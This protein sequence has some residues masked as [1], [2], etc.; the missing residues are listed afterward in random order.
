MLP[1]NIITLSH[2][3]ALGWLSPS[4]P[5]LRSDESHLVTGPVSSDE[6]SWIGSSLCIGGFIGTI[7]FG[8]I[9][10]M[11][12][13]KKAL[14]LLVFPHLCFWLLVL[15]ST[16]IYHLYIARVCAGLT[17]GGTLRTVSL[18]ITEISENK[19][20]GRLGSYLI[21]FLCTGTLL[22]FIAG[23]Y[24]SFFTVPYVMLMFPVTF[25]V[26]VLFLP[27]TPQ[28]LMS[29]NKADEAWD[30]LMFYRTCGA[31][32]VATESV[33]EEFQVLKQTLEHQNSEKL[34]LKDFRKF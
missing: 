11:L 16:H 8:K 4:L 7:A 1:V 9:A 14:L 34:Q 19:I 26:S 12:G 6:V 25:F 32:K 3:C 13:K 28:S 20:R 17:G 2:G 23:T 27:D 21:L 18:Y 5:Y 30:S 33:K 24:L 31:N 10:E 15:T 22:V 29:K